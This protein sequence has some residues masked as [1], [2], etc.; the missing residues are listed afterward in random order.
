MPINGKKNNTAQ[1]TFTIFLYYMLYIKGTLTS[2]GV[3]CK[4]IAHS[5]QSC[6]LYLLAKVPGLETSVT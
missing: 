3:M 6:L 1:I 2:F 5:I 4:A